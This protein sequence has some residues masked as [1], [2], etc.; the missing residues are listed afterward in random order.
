MGV[1]FQ[2]ANGVEMAPDPASFTIWAAR[3]LQPWWPLW[4]RNLFLVNSSDKLG[5]RVAAASFER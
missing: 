4:S 3:W 1:S 2:L 5:W